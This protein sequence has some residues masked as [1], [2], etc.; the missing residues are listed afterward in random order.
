[1]INKLIIIIISFFIGLFTGFY[2]G[3]QLENKKQEYKKIFI[4]HQFNKIA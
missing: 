2:F 1:M 3:K 4:Q